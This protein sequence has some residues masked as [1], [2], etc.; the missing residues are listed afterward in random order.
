MPRPP[1][2]SIAPV[3]LPPDRSP[4]FLL[5]PTTSGR[6]LVAPFRKRRRGPTS[7]EAALVRAVGVHL[8]GQLPPGRCWIDPV[9]GAAT[10]ASIAEPQ[11]RRRLIDDASFA[12]VAT[13]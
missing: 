8:V 1:P 2:K 10:P 7:E 11:I 3:A 5:V 6:V 13:A 9:T 4:P 12:V